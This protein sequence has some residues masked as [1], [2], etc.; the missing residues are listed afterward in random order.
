MK[1]SIERIMPWASQRTVLLA[2]ALAMPSITAA[3]DADDGDP[4]QNTA[5]TQAE[6]GASGDGED[7][8]TPRPTVARGVASVITADGALRTRY[9]PQTL[10]FPAAG[11]VIAVLVAPGDQVTAGDELARMD[12]L[13]LDVPIAAGEA[14]LVAARGALAQA[15]SGGT[16][17]TA[18]LEVDRAKNQRWQQQINRDSICGRKDTPFGSQGDCDAADAAVN[19]AEVGVQIAELNLETARAAQG[20]EIASAQ[21]RVRQAEVSLARA[22]A[23]RERATIK[24]PFDG[25]VIEVHVLEGV[26]ASPGSPAITLAPNGALSFVTTTLGERNV[27]DVRAGASATI[28]L[29]AFPDQPIEGQVARVDPSGQVDSSGAV[30]FSV[31]LDIESEG[32]PLREGMTGRVE[33]E[34]HDE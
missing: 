16:I 31:H 7:E 19:V 5:A 25:S 3:C 34:V 6:A 4:D 22:R 26:Q 21:A 28:T 18:R 24:A 12:L 15:Q 8:A 10:S 30:V 1:R 2:I 14:E 32:L 27:G 13:A 9:S 20:G 17:E 23:D 29:N 11:D 33:I